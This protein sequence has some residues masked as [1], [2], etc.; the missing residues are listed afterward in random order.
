MTTFIELKLK[1]NDKNKT[2]NG[3]KSETAPAFTVTN[4]QTAL[5]ALGTYVYKVDGDFG[6]KTVNALK[7]FQWNSSNIGTYIKNKASTKNAAQKTL[8][9][10]GSL[11][12]KSYDEIILWEKEKRATTGDLVRVKSGT[13]TNIEPS[14]A[15][16]K[17]TSSKVLKDELVVSKKAIDLL[18]TLNKNAKDKK[19]TIKVN[20]A[21]RVHGVKVA[22]AVVT[23]ANKSQHLIGHAID[24]NIVDGSNWNTA[25]NF[26][27]GKE[28]QNAKDFIKLVKKESI[29][30]GGNFTDT[31]T[32]HFDVLLSSTTFAYDAKFFFNQRSISLDQPI[33]VETL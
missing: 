6:A 3:K 12:Q 29:R 19:L 27:K 31:D 15:F 4:L 28:S 18:K 2:W 11:N 30:W 5:K 14:T 16:S 1:D 10:T 21:F 26:K 25:A 22:N 32:P 9:I 33:P 13:I 20:Q 7:L 17:I 24:C 23:P 8:A